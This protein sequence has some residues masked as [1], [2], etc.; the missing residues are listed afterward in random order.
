MKLIQRIATSSFL[1][2]MILFAPSVTGQEEVTKS[3]TVVRPA[4][5][6]PASF[7]ISAKSA[8]VQ[9]DPTAGTYV[10]VTRPDLL[11]PLQPLLRWKRQQGYRVETI[12]VETNNRDSIQTRLQQRYNDASAV[13]PAQRYV[14]LVGDVNRI[15]AFAGRHTPSG[16]YNRASDLYYGE[17]TGDYVP[18]A[19]VGR[20]SVADSGELAAVVAKIIAYEQ[21][22]WASAAHRLLLAAGSESRTPAP[23]T[24]NGQVNYLAQLAAQQH[25][26]IDTVCFRNPSS[27]EMEDSL[28]LALGGENA[29]VNYTA[30]CTNRGWE[31]P[32][33][34]F[35]N[36]DTLDNPTPTLYVNNCCLSNAFDGTCFGEQLLRRPSGGAAGVI[37]ATNE[38]LWNEDYYWAV[39][40]KCPPT[41]FPTYDSSRSGA[42]DTLLI[43]GTETSAHNAE[44]YTLGAMMY[45]GCRAV[46]LAGSPYDAYYWEI[47]CLLGDPSM[48]PYMGRSDSLVWSLPDS[49]AAGSTSLHV[50]CTPFSRISATQDTS[51]LATTVSD[52]DGN[53][54]LTFDR[55]L[56]GDSL[57]LTVTRPNAIPL[58]AHIPFTTPQD[59]R[60]AVTQY[61]L[62]DSLL[63]LTVRNVGLE[64]ANQHTLTLMQDSNDCAIG[65]VVST[66]AGVNIEM[67]PPQHETE[68][69]LDLGRLHI[70]SEPLLSAHLQAADST[71]GIYSTL[72]LLI[73]TEDVR[74]KIVRLAVVDSLHSPVRSLI[75]GG[76]YLLAVTLSH[77]TDSVV[78]EI[79]GQRAASTE[80]PTCHLP[81]AIGE[82]AEHVH[83]VLTAHKDQWR[84]HRETWILSYSTWERFETGD[85]G[86]LPWQQGTL[87][88]WTIDSSTV[89]EG[90]YCARSAAIGHA[91]KSTLKLEVETLVDDSL[92]FYFKVSSEAH[93]WLYFYIDGRKV[94]YWSG[95]SGWR[96][97]ARLLAAGRHQLEWAYEKDASQS[98]RDD[99]ALIDDLQLPLALWERPYGTSER[100]S[101]LSILPTAEEKWHFDIHPNPTAGRVSIELNDCPQ[102]RWIAVYDMCGRMVDKIF[103]AANCNSTQYFTHSLR[104][105]VYSLVLYDNMGNHIKKLIVTK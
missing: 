83:V 43:P 59:G 52:A 100:D 75:P 67:L 55:S 66:P 40:A 98:E 25:P 35:N 84:H 51:L 14:L 92:S 29:L 71:Q 73:P 99:C 97:Y 69:T 21:G 1:I 86:N 102:D 44:G 7:T 41:L 64:T 22:R 4:D 93:D 54:L 94:G 87:Y 31:N 53:A 78:L 61:H 80:E 74:P 27:L 28:L 65:A 46:S 15:Q 11:Q 8:T 47:Y 48:T 79:E 50:V 101:S 49:I 95:N 30:H 88:P 18:E 68:I 105:G 37:G 19:Y 12:C 45:A 60:L 26:D 13:R 10:V 56:W 104:F 76:N 23:V 70:G 34:T 2:G 38:T 3:G 91:Q 58:T 62:E 57:T 89:H 32:T 82:E 16:L 85:F 9:S 20:L 6:I 77:P 33:I 39:G 36:I 63:H 96:R 81:F 90:H 17:Y 103:I 42:F 5:R 72:H 24:T